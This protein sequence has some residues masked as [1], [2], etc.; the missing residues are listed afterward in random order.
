MTHGLVYHDGGR[1]VIVQFSLVAQA[2][3]PPKGEGVHWL[4][5]SLDGRFVRIRFQP[6]DSLFF[7]GCLLD[8][9]ILFAAPQACEERFCR[10]N[11]MGQVSQQAL[12]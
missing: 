7:R 12:C 2:A 4:S 8:L 11:Q 6:C 3:V 5:Q 9:S 1:R 10:A